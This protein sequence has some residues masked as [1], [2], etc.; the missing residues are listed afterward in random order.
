[1]VYNNN[2]DQLIEK[3][4]GKGASGKFL[5]S[6]DY[7]YNTRGWLTAINSVNVGFDNAAVPIEGLTPLL[8]ILTPTSTGEGTI[9][10]MAVSPFLKNSIL[11]PPPPMIDDKPD[12]YS[13]N[14]Y[15]EDADTRL[16]GAPQYNGNISGTA[17]QVAG[18]AAQSYGYTYDDLDRLTNAKYYDITTTTANRRTS[19]TFSTDFK[20]NE[21]LTYDKRGNILSLQRN[22][23]NAG[24]WTADGSGYTA[25]TYGMIDNMTYAYN[26][27]NQVTT[28]TDAS[29]PDKGFKFSTLGGNAKSYTYDANGNLIRDDNK[30]ITDIKY[31]YLNLPEVIEFTFGSSAYRSYIKFVYDAS[32]VKLR[33]IV[34]SYNNATLTSEKIFDYVNGVEYDGNTLQRLSHTEGSIS[35]QD[36]GTFAHEFVLRDHLGNTRV[37]FSDLNNDGFVTSADIKQINHYYPFGLNMEGNWN[38]AVGKNKYQYN[39]KELNSDFGLEWN[40]YGARFYDPS[41]ARWNAIDP[42]AIKYSSHNPY[43]YVMNRPTVMIDPDGESCVITVDMEKKTITI[44]ASLHFYGGYADANFA[45]RGG[46]AKVDNFV[47]GMVDTWKA[48][49]KD[50][51]EVNGE[52]FETNFNVTGDYKND[53]C[54][55]ADKMKNSN[56]SDNFIALESGGVNGFESNTG[57]K[58]GGNSAIINV[59]QGKTTPAHELGHLLG[60]DHPKGDVRSQSIMTTMRNTL[61]GNKISREDLNRRKVEKSDI[62]DVIHGTNCGSGNVSNQ[63]DNNRIYYFNSQTKDYKYAAPNQ[64][65]NKCQ[66]R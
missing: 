2:R 36:D 21:S 22:G 27:K 18:R 12:L 66:S 41:T 3:N 56:A 29:L 45:G 61:N 64:I 50:G 16:G 6:I 4:I 1:M 35:R 60:L 31:N 49:A 39:S 37:T 33:K 58:P 52:K 63:G 34:Q 26:D 51:I 28:I 8:K 38:G 7:G 62:Q 10:N 24:T 23:L 53:D 32:G 5:Q 19:Y 13:Q 48:G 59:D 42:L 30:R 43:S 55:V 65:R 9:I 11:A 40:D 54:A 44:S 17:W 20:Y 57:S 46:Q 14:I 25:A 47:K 15:Y